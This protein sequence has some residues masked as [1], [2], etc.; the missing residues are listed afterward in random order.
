MP[1]RRL[2]DQPKI[3]VGDSIRSRFGEPVTA[4]ISED[5]SQYSDQNRR[6]NETCPVCGETTEGTKRKAATL[7]PRFKNSFS[8]GLGVWVHEECFERCPD[9]N[10][11]T[12]VPW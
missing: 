7:H 5:P 10:E 3:D 2:Q 6:K 8:Y 9:A 12:P 4:T 1:H 11:P